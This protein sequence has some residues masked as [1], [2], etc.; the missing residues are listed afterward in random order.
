[1]LGEDQKL[2]ID[3]LTAPLVQEAF[4][5]YAEGETVKA[6]VESFNERGLTTKKNQPFNF[7]S[8]NVFF[9]NRKYIGAYKYQD[10]IIPG[11]VP[12]LVSK[13]V[14]SRL[15]E[16]KVKNKHALARAKADEEYLLTVIAASI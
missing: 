9:N 5:Q 16:R 7:N 10:V 12:A 13:E 1:M 15:Q 14:F 2:L 6:I 11:D 4:T 3:P 8:F